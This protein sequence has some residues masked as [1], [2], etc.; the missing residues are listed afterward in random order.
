[1]IKPFFSAIRFLTVL[2]VPLS[3]CG[4]MNALRRS[5]IFFP[6]V[7]LIVGVAVAFV[8]AGL[9]L[10]LPPAVASVLTALS[11]AGFSGGLHMDGLADTADGF[12]SSRPRERILEI[13]KDSRIGAMG[14]MAIVFVAA[15]K[16]TSL[17]ALPAHARFWTILIVPVAGRF[18][19]VLLMTALP[20]VRGEEGLGSIFST[21]RSWLN[22]LAALLFLAALG[23][24]GLGIPG[25]IVP[26]AC[27]VVLVVFAALCRSKIR[28]WT[29]DTL[30][31]ACEILELVPPLTVLVWQYAS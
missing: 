10:I 28:G 5:I 9:M 1:M 14:V 13:M 27:I 8:D 21:N 31:A 3:W 25:M 15:L 7:G 20:Y 19:P 2:P 16:I 4:D 17:A 12:F 23:K 24:R 18:A 30:G 22:V 6:V 29:G 11:L 26:L